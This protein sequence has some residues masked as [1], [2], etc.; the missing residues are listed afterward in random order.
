[1][2]VAG[3]PDGC[4]VVMLSIVCMTND[5]RHTRTAG[6]LT[7]SGS[8]DVAGRVFRARNGSTDD[9]PDRL[10]NRSSIHSAA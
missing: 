3:L 6:I 1:M 2:R 4:G 8:A 9:V 7:R 10:G 5:S